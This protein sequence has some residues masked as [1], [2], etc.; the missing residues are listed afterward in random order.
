MRPR[1]TSTRSWRCWTRSSI[2]DVSPEGVD[3]CFVAMAEN[4]P[5]T[6]GRA[7]AVH[8]HT[9]YWQMRT[10]LLDWLCERLGDSSTLV[11]RVVV[12]QLSTF[13]SHLPGIT[14][15]PCALADSDLTVRLSV[16][17]YCRYWRSAHDVAQWARTCAENDP[18]PTIRGG[19]C[20]PWSGCAKRRG[21]R[22]VARDA[23]GAKTTT[24]NPEAERSG[25]RRR[26]AVTSRRAWV[27][28]AI[29]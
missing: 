16:F 25:S 7:A 24:G 4:A 18:D 11:R 26:S 20:T 8:V 28:F 1:S 10:G 27:G 22:R 3:E 6:S 21:G 14:D 17:E 13:W 29:L 9:R 19:R 2:A 12:E 23:G 15:Q 5:L